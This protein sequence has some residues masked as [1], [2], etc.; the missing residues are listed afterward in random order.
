MVIFVILGYL[1]LRKDSK[2][3]GNRC[4]ALFFWIT[5]ATLGFNLLYLFSTDTAFIS[6][7]NIVTAETANLSIMAVL[8]GILV[9]YKGER[10]IIQSKKIYTFM[11]LMA[12]LV[13]IHVCI[14]NAVYVIDNDPKWSYPFGIY[15]LVFSQGLMVATFYFSFA[16][17]RDL[18]PEIRK[19]F[20]K[21]LIGLAFLDLTL[22]SVTIDNLDIFGAAYSTI[23]ALLNFCVVIA[24]I[25]IWLG[26][27]RRE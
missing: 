7:M 17:Y 19:K 2:Y 4:F 13:I 26:I 1:V 25:L 15:E 3:W 14:P 9:I 21:Y 20:V 12:V 10:E 8:I 6:T 27:V 16:F 11:I 23:G 18:S 24:A 5:A 22:V